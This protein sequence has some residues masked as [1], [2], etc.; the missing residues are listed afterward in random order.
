MGTSPCPVQVISAFH[1]LQTILVEPLPVLLVKD[2]LKAAGNGANGAESNEIHSISPWNIWES[3]FV[4]WDDGDVMTLGNHGTNS[5]TVQSSTAPRPTVKSSGVLA[6]RCRCEASLR[7]QV[8][9]AGILRFPRVSL[10]ILQ[11]KPK[12]T[13]RL[14]HEIW[15]FGIFQQENHGKPGVLF[16]VFFLSQTRLA[17]NVHEDEHGMLSTCQQKEPLFSGGFR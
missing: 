15:Y 5:Q 13:I 8:S 14:S 11:Q 4:D 12:E 2:I 1:T 3:M 6:N 10:A 9:G 16:S 7:C 17:S